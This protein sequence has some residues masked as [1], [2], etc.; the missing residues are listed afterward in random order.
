MK[1]PSV[2]DSITPQYIIDKAGKKTGVILD[3]KTFNTLVEELEDMYD[4]RQAE[5]I[6]AAGEK[7]KGRTLEELEE[8]LHKKD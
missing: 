6:I 1:T 7:E 3:L 2:L 8:S 5:Q 4:V